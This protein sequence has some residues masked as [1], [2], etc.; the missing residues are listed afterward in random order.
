MAGKDSAPPTAKKRRRRPGYHKDDHW[1]EKYRYTMWFGGV[2]F[3]AFQIFAFGASIMGNE[4]AATILRII[5]YAGPL[6]GLMFYHQVDYFVE[7]LTSSLWMPKG[8]DSGPAHSEGEALVQRQDFAGALDW[9]TNA[10]MADRT[11]WRAQLRIVEILLEHFDDRERVAEERSRL[12]RIAGVPEGT[13]V[14]TALALG[15]DWVAL[16]HPD[17]A[18]NAY[19]GLLWKLSEGPDADEARRR[20]K[21]LGVSYEGSATAPAGPDEAGETRTTES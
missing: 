20:L 5:S 21:D 11:D 13:W 3:G 7:K 14:E 9:F 1:Y 15:R 19:K 18:V 12:L 4:T 17:R 8:G 16:G 6:I 10:V 2:I